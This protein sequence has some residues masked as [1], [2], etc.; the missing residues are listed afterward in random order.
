MTRAEARIRFADEIPTIVACTSI[1]GCPN[2]E[3]AEAHLLD[4]AISTCMIA[5]HFC[6][7]GC[8]EMTQAGDFQPLQVC[9]VCEFTTNQR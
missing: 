9:P 6:P 2:E 7:N 1:P 8:G 5:A 3:Q 4:H